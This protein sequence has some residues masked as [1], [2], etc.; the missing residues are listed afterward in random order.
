[1]NKG[2]FVLLLVLTACGSDPE[3]LTAIT[4]NQSIISNKLINPHSTNMCTQYVGEFCMFGGGQIVRYNDDSVLL[5]GNW[6]FEYSNGTGDTDTD[7]NTASILFLPTLSDIGY[8]RISAFVAR[9]TGYKNMYLV[10]SK[11]TGEASLV[12]DTNGNATIDAGDTKI[13]LLTVSNW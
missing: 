12:Y 6:L 4:A 7:Q 10:Y 2:I 1:M 8:I 3:A 13:T 9:G 5:T 11:L